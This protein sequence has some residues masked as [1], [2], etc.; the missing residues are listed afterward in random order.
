MRILFMGTP[1]FAVP[2]LQALIDAGHDVCAAVTKP[3]TMKGR[4]GKLTPCPVKALAEQYGIPV[5]TPEKKLNDSFAEELAAYRPEVIV[6]IAYGKIIPDSILKLA[7]LGCINVHASLLPAYRGAAPIQW[8]VLNGEKEAGVTIMKVGE[9]LD[10]GDIYAREA[11]RLDAEETSDSLFDKLADLG[12]SLLVKTL[13]EIAAGTIV[14]VPQ[15]AESPTEYARMIVKSDGLIDWSR[16]AEE[17]D[18]FVRGMN[19]WP[20]AFSRMQGKTVKVWRAGAT[21]EETGLP[22]GSLALPDKETLLVQTGRGCL[23][24]KELQLEG[25]KRMSAADFLRG[26]QWKAGQRFTDE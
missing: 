8:A 22:A 2:S 10:T 5:L 1:D 16:P 21:Q 12:A 25:K 7:P 4:S 26:S 20:G 11:V 14:P 3:D 13:P 17:L 9:G 19:S 24:I 18:C 23:Q 6:V 15:P